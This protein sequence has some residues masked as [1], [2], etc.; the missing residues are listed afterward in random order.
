MTVARSET[1]IDYFNRSHPLHRVKEAI[2][3]KARRRMY[4]RV[5]AIERFTP[6]TRVLDA[7]TTPDLE[8]PYNNFFERW[9]PH[10]GQVTACG[11]EDCSNLKSSFPGLRFA[12]ITG[13][14]LPFSDRVFDI[15]LSFAVLEHVGTREKQRRFMYELA[16][17]ADSFILYTPYRY[18]PIEMHTLLPLTH[19]MPTR[20]YRA[21]WRAC[22]MRFWADERNL[23]LLSM[24]DIRD[25]LPTSGAA[26]IRLLSTLGWPS[27]IEVHWWRS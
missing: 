13:D 17:V 18:F 27:N 2:A 23:N 19:W 8:I 22:G 5:L 16:R 10:T 15:A 26:T 3:L 21:L 14:D 9:Y 12:R 7:G 25:I 11:I 1:S 24:R 6:S 4:E 20:A